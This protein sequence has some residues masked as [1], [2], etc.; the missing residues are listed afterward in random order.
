MSSMQDQH[1]QLPWEQPDWLE[2]VTEWIHAQLAASGWQVTGPV[3]IMHQR[4]WSAFAR[5]STANGTAYF[6]APAPAYHYE[7]ALT[8]ALAH[9]RPDCTVRLLGVDLDRGWLLSADAG[10]TLRYADS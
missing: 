5:V 10:I 9:W 4:P 2:Q 3:E 6:K 7:V 8:Q 1:A